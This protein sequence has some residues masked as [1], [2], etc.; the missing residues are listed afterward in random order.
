MNFKVSDTNGEVLDASEGSEPLVYIHGVKNI[1]PGLEAALEGKKVG[2][3]VNVEVAPADAYGEYHE[4]MVQDIPADAF[5]GV[6]NIEPGMAFHA[7]SPDGNPIQIIVTGV[8]GDMVSVDG[9]HPLAGKDLVF[10][11]KVLE[12]RDATEDELEH[13][14]VHGPSCSH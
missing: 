8:E 11:V 10:D 2:D 14:H 6:D 7:E 3:E 5:E 1:I 13:G 9:N 12:I 4:E